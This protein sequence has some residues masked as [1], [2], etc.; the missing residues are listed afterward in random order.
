L[1]RRFGTAEIA[2]G[3]S[4]S[5]IIYMIVMIPIMIVMIPIDV[6]IGGLPND[7]ADVVVRD[8]PFPFVANAAF[9]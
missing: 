8:D 5:T 3:F 2:G 7:R 9:K 4:L 1:L 6:S